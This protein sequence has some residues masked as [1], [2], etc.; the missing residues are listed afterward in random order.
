[1]AGSHLRALGRAVLFLSSLGCSLVATPVQTPPPLAG[2]SDTFQSI[3]NWP[4][5]TVTAFQ[6]WALAAEIG[7]DKL[8]G[9]TRPGDLV[10]A[11]VS[12]D[13][14]RYVPNIGAPGFSR[15]ICW[16]DGKTVG[17]AGVRDDWALNQQ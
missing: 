12:R 4:A 14:I 6:G 10:Y 5:G 7:I 17:T 8:D 11:V 13:R 1:M 2:T 9:V 3:C 15:M 16:T